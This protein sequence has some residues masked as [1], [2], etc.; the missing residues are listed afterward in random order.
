MFSVAQPGANLNETMIDEN[1][2]VH[3]Q[4]H[5]P[6]GSAVI[7]LEWSKQ[8]LSMLCILSQLA[9]GVGDRKCPVKHKHTASLASLEWLAW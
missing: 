1:S 8:D 6:F 4:L 7:W 3:W 2:K 5:S 9:L